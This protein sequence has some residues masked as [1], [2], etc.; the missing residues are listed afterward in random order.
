MGASIG[1]IVAPPVI[2]VPPPIYAAPPPIVAGLPY[3]RPPPIVAAPPPVTAPSAPAVAPPPVGPLLGATVPP[4]IV[5]LPPPEIIVAVAPPLIIFT[6]PAFALFIGPPFLAFATIGPGWWDS[7]YVTGGF[8]GLGVGAAIA[9]FGHTGP[10]FAGMPRGVHGWPAS[11]N[12]ASAPVFRSDQN[13]PPPGSDLS[14]F[15]RVDILINNAAI[16][17]HKPFTELT[18]ADW[19]LI[20]SVVLD[21]PL[22]LTR[23]LI[24]PMVENRYGRILFF[25]GDGSISASGSGRTHLS[26]AKMG[27]IGTARG[28][29]SEFAP[30]NIRVN[31]VSPG[32]IDTRR[33]HPEWYHGRLCS[34]AATARSEFIAENTGLLGDS[35]IQELSEERFVGTLVYPVADPFCRYPRPC[36]VPAVRNKRQSAGVAGA[37]AH[38]A[39]VGFCIS[40]SG[41]VLRDLAYLGFNQDLVGRQVF[42]GILPVVAGSRRTCVNWQFAQ[43]GRYSRQHEDHSYGDDQFPL[44]YPTLSDPIS[45]RSDGILQRARDAGVCPKV[46]H[47]DTESDFWQARSS[48]IVT[49]TSGSDIAMPDEVRVYA[50]SGVPHAAFRPL[51]KPPLSVARRRHARAAR[52]G[53][54]DIPP[55]AGSEIPERPAA[56]RL[57]GRAANREHSLP[58]VRAINGC[59][60]QRSR[61]HPPCLSRIE[62]SQFLTDR[63]VTIS[64]G[65]S[66]STDSNALI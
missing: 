46:L 43:A 47:L 49:D 23:A 12:S 36:V 52:R 15:G 53:P 44:S 24:E 1:V 18:D 31:V 19:E 20:R 3:I 7:G 17:P 37:P 13:P 6:P 39:R 64:A 29:A 59:R 10:G 42:D 38:P 4:P 26:A 27:L 65:G 63:D 66:S 9:H 32:S 35:S 5:V 61:R 41:R 25:C 21:G 48:L 50:V 62:K 40:Q 33:D 2:V 16:R 22:H 54:A 14:E 30:R 28:L 8:A 58:G 56:A 11:L 34:F 51:A 55:A 60:R 45:G 57:L